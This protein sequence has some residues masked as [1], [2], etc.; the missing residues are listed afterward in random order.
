MSLLFLFFRRQFHRWWHFRCIRVFHQPSADLFHGSHRRLLGGGWEKRTGA[1]LQ[2]PRALGGDDNKTVSALL[3]VV[4]NSVHRVILQ[5]LSHVFLN[6][7]SYLTFQNSR[8]W[9]ELL[10]PFWLCAAARL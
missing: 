3:T 2:L 4:G 8:G 1:I 7:N 5:S 9:A 10:L 6:L